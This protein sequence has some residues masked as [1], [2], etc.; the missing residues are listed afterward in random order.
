MFHSFIYFFKF[1]LGLFLFAMS[2]LYDT[3]EPAVI[4]DEMLMTA[5]EEQGQKGE[6]GKIAME[7]GVDFKDVKSLRLDFKSKIRNHNIYFEFFFNLNNFFKDILPID[8]LWP[9][10]NLVRLQLDNN[11]IE[12]IDG[13]DALVH[14][15]WLDLSFNNIQRIDGLSKLKKL[16][17]LS[18]F[19]NRITEIENL[20]NQ[21]NLQVFSIGNN[22]ISDLKN[23]CFSLLL[24]LFFFTNETF[25][26]GLPSSICQFKNCEFGWKSC[27]PRSRF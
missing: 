3:V 8:N 7:E 21:K 10:I 5:I 26:V 1:N 12:K 24:F 22:N 27:L 15:V 25:S 6:A 2:R 14:L 11:I 16:E 20:E 19:N 17:D 4:D 9:F 13:L 18:L 23:V